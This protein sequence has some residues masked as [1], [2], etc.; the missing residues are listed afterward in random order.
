MRSPDRALRHS[1]P[2][3]IALVLNYPANPTAYTASLDFC[4]EVVKYCRE[5]DIFILSD[6]AYSEI[7][8]DEKDP[9]PSVLQVPGAMDITV[10]FTSMSKTYSMPGWCVGFAVGR[11]GRAWCRGRVCQYV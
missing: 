3:P 10:A 11:I 7:Y 8:F 5:H 4:T 2:T 9:P 1:I 6:L